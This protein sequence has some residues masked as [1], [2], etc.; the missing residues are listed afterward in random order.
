M[1]NGFEPLAIRVH[2]VR[3]ETEDDDSVGEQL[4]EVVRQSLRKGEFPS[5]AVVVAAGRADILPL[6]PMVDGGV[7]LPAALAGL[8]ATMPDG[9]RPV[10]AVGIVGPFEIRRSDQTNEVRQVV[11]VFL[12]WTDCRWWH[13]SIDAEKSGSQ[14]RLKDFTER[15]DRAVDGSARPDGLGGWWSLARRTGASLSFIPELP[16]PAAIADLVH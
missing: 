4:I 2:S 13:W 6:Q 1:S 11:T 7:S 12:E 5:A 3:L 14:L 15:T 8:T 9:T 10:L 16:R